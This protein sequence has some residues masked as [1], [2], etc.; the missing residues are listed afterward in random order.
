M[1]RT[2]IWTEPAWSDLEEAAAYLGRSSTRSGIEL[3]AEAVRVAQSLAELS[4]RGARIDEIGIPD[5]LRQ[6][7]VGQHRMIYRASAEQ[8]HIVAFVHGSRD[9]FGL[10]RREGRET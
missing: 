6:L 2:V 1:A 9:L 3:V 8:V 7:I 4:E 5:D 10:W